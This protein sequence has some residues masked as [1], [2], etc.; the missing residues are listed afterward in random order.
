MRKTLA[1]SPWIFDK[2]VFDPETSVLKKFAGFVYLIISRETGV[3]YI[4]KKTFWSKRKQP[5][6]KRKTVES[7]WKRYRGSCKEFSDYQDAHPDETFLRTILSLHTHPG[8]MTFTETDWQ[9][10]LGVL[11]DPLSFNLNI[12]GK[13]FGERIRTLKT[14][15]EGLLGIF[16]NTDQR[17]FLESFREIVG[18]GH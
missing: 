4:G 13:F 14:R 5:D 15:S 9:F 11:A 6:G 2:K 17:A 12:L 18:S 1:L 10:R 7:D 8:D 3:Y 16:G